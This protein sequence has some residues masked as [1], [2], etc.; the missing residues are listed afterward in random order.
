VEF[1][2]AETAALSGAT[3]LAE[4]PLGCRCPDIE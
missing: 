3:I 2:E 1:F 4:E